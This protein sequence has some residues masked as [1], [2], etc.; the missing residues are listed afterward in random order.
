MTKKKE[1]F[2]DAFIR[3]LIAERQDGFDQTV[4]RISNRAQNELLTFAQQSLIDYRSSDSEL[5][6]IAW[7]DPNKVP[8]EKL[9][10]RLENV[11]A[12]GNPGNWTE[13]LTLISMIAF[14]LGNSQSYIECP[15]GSFKI[16]EPH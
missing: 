11:L 13:V 8:I 7:Y 5:N 6:Q 2:N 12:Q 14:R 3:M 1:G 16:S 15:R 4:K 10:K 9:E